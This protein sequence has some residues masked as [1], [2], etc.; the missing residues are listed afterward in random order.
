M[1]NKKREKV[2]D[3]GVVRLHK[4][5]Y[6]EIYHAAI[7]QNFISSSARD[8]EKL[9]QLIAEWR[10]PE[11]IERLLLKLQTSSANSGAA[12]MAGCCGEMSAG[13]ENGRDKEWM[14][15]SLER[16]KSLH[17]ASIE[18]LRSLLPRLK[19]NAQSE[20]NSKCE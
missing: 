12:A 6:D 14:L 9:E 20:T 8:L 18:K 7:V 11:R 10:N 3:T 4:A 2:V 13:L 15:E 1:E 5:A 19:E 17:A 16:L